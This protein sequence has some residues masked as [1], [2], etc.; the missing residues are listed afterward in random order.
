[1]FLFISAFSALLAVALGAFGAH[2]LQGRLDE[3]ALAIWRTAV[4]YH[5]WHALALGWVGVLAERWPEARRLAWAGWLFVAGMVLFSGSLY[6]LA[7]T[8]AR[9]LGMVTPFGGLAFLAGWL[10]AGLSFAGRKD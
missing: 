4:D 7:V 3:S 9:W 10:M 1:M 2:G 5:M 6:L 8:G